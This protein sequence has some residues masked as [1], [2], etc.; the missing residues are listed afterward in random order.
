LLAPT[1]SHATGTASA[2]VI[3][4]STLQGTPK[5]SERTD[6]RECTPAG[7]KTERRAHVGGTH[8][9]NPARAAPRALRNTRRLTPVTTGLSKNSVTPVATGLSKTIAGPE[10]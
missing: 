10:G 9:G 4:V 8:R 2:S 1:R 5:R 7:P 3:V 6:E